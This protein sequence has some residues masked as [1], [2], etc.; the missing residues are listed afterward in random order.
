MERKL[1]YHKHKGVQRTISVDKEFINIEIFNLEGLPEVDTNVYSN[2]LKSFIDLIELEDHVSIHNSK[3]NVYFK[4]ETFNYY[5]EPGN[6]MVILYTNNSNL[7]G[8]GTRLAS[9]VEID[10]LKSHIIKI[11]Y[12][13]TLL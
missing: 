5:I 1:Y 9:E 8:Y 11:F 2:L 6:D 3:Y 12:G 13:T 7:I 10:D 4:L